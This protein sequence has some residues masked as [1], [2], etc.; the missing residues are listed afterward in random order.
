MSQK[1][2]EPNDVLAKQTP[3]TKHLKLNLSLH[4]Q[5]LYYDFLHI[6][7][8]FARGIECLGGPACL[9][10]LFDAESPREV[11]TEDRFS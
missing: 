10:G 9:I 11:S 7:Y 6:F 1:E 8:I 5:L 2:T 4:F 3:A